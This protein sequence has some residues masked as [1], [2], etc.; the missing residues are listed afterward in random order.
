MIVI[1]SRDMA[2]EGAADSK[3]SLPTMLFQWICQS[4]LAVP[5]ASTVIVNRGWAVLVVEAFF[6][7]VKCGDDGLLPGR[8]DWFLNGDL[9]KDGMDD[10]Y[11]AGASLIPKI[12]YM[13]QLK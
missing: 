2:D 1:G 8:C 10:S 9:L 12:R 6:G 11:Q 7:L 5:K 3:W 4:P 13:E